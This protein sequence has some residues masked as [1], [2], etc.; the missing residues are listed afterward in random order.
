MSVIAPGKDAARPSKEGAATRSGGAYHRKH[1][2]IKP[3]RHFIREGRKV[4]IW[5]NR[6][7]RT[8]VATSAISI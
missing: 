6:I 2:K 7:S 5:G 4:A 1:R 8:V 3:V